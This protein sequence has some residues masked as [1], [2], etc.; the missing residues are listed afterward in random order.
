MAMIKLTKAT[1]E[2]LR[3]PDPSGKQTLYWAEG[4]YRGLGILVS[5]VAATKTWVCQ[6]KLKSGKTRRV[7]IGPATVLMIEEAWQQARDALAEM[8]QGRD[9]KLSKQQRTNAAVTVREVFAAYLA[10]SSNQRPKTREMYRYAADTHLAPWLDLPLRDVTHEMVEARF[11]AITADVA[12]RACA[13]QIK[14][15]VNVDGRTTANGAMRL[16]RALWNHQAERD[17]SLPRNPTWVLRRQWHDI[18]RRSR[19]VESERLPDFYD[20]ARRLPSEIQRDLVLFALFTGMREREAAGLTW[21][22]VDL[23]QRVIRVPASRMKAD[24]EFVL[25]MSDVA[26]SL[27]VGRRAYGRD[28][29]YVFPGHGALG[30]CQSFTFA[31]KQIAEMTEIKISPHDLRRTFASVAAMSAISPL[32]LKLLLAHSTKSD[33]TEGYEL[34]SL[35]ELQLNAQKVADK[36][37]E[38]C[39]IESLPEGVA[40]MGA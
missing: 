8:Y 30:Y 17:P 3:A 40:R 34:M 24:R 39:G 31:L 28:G 23:A 37:K 6:A 7:T 35:S 18:Q 25:P 10:A 13:G 1:V 2:R 20:A 26:H 16:F 19:R 36:L 27:L 21:S 29:D 14:G 4:D 12:K 9:P 5:G 38:L 33:V 11:R 32:A 15:G 22:E